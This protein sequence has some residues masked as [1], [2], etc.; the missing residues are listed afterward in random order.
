MP[1]IGPN[2]RKSCRHRLR[3]KAGFQSSIP[4][5]TVDASTVSAGLG[6]GGAGSR[7]SGV[8]RRT[9][10]SR[11]GLLLFQRSGGGYSPARAKS[12]SNLRPRRKGRNFHSSAEIRG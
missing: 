4:K 7:T 2:T 8:S 1:S 6:G 11:L 9:T 3:D 5:E 12:V 10:G